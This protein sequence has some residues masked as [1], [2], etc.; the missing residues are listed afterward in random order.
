MDRCLNDD[1]LVTSGV[2]QGTALAPLLFLIYITDLSKNIL[3][4]I[5]LYADDHDVFIY[6]T[7]GSENDHI[8]L[9]QDLHKLQEW[10]NAWLISFNPTKCEMICINNKK[11]P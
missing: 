3:S 5:K 2:S 1:T 4:P 9:Q 7:I 10:T 11:N 6:R 8:I